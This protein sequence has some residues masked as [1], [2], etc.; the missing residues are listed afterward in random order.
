MQ[1]NLVQTHERKAQEYLN[2]KQPKL[3]IPEFKAVLAADPNNLNALANLGVLLY[4]EQDYAEA[5]PY[6][7]KAVAKEPDL[8]KIRALLGLAEKS[9]GQTAE[10]RTDLAAAVPQLAEPGIRVQAGLALIEIYAASQ[11]LDK[12]AGTVSLLQQVAPTDTRVL[13]TAYRIYSDLA[14]EA[15]LDLSLVA[16]ESGQ[17]HQA[18]AH[19]LYRARDL[20]GTIANLRKAVAADPNLPGIHYELA[21]ALRNSP[22]PKVRDQAEQEYKLA[23]DREWS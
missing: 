10:S 2:Q 17:M 1:A 3:A 16:P 5:S 18:M 15:M 23:C 21:E 13:Y 20:E 4:F 7:K 9:L 22:D 14:G 6:L 19:E 12:A 11:E 8:A